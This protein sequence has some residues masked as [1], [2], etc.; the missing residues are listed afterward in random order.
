MNFLVGELRSA[1]ISFPSGIAWLLAAWLWIGDHVLGALNAGCVHLTSQACGLHQSKAIHLLIVAAAAIGRPGLLVAL[2]LL[3]LLVGGTAN[4]FFAW[5]LGLRWKSAVN[6]IMDWYSPEDLEFR[7]KYPKRWLEAERVRRQG[8]T[9]L[10]VLL[11]AL[12]VV[13]AL[14]RSESLLWLC[15]IVPLA[16]MAA[17]G[18]FAISRY[19]E[20]IGDARDKTVA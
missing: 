18:G 7:E 6:L 3:A 11:P 20:I 2:V 8:Q 13:I 1:R 14:A 17:H 9:R 12:L 19:F 4:F 15:G 16:A 10:V 5:L